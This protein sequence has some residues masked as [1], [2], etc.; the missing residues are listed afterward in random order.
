MLG[1]ELVDSISNAKTAASEFLV[2]PMGQMG[3]VIK[4]GDCVM[5]FDLYLSRNDKCLVP[6]PFAPEEVTFADFFFGSHD[7][8][9]H[10]DKPIWKALSQASPT[11][12]FVVPRMHTE[13]LSESLDIDI[14]RFAGISDG[15]T[16]DLGPIK[17]T[18]V[19]AAHEFLSKDEASGEFPY[20][21]FIVEI[22][23]RRIYHA[24]DTCVYEGLYAKLRSRG[25]IDLMFLPIN[26]RSGNKYRSGI[27]GNM[28]YQEA[29]DLSGAI[30]PSIV[31]PC[32][33]NMHSF[34]LEDPQLFVDYLSAKYPKQKYALPVPFAP[35][36]L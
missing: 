26:G 17:V 7:H 33:Y 35:I 2:W 16:A 15:L 27:I 24:G 28:T 30:A 8:G 36:R 23:G 29:V 11:A 12:R 20:M 31:I 6:A 13:G 18:G 19:A 9:D 22:D 25:G 32:H 5:V 1:K 34:N 10:I 14:S 21:G 3:F 4:S